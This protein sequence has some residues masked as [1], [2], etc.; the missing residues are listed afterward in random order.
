[1]RDSADL[2]SALDGT[3]TILSESPSHSANI[4][5]IPSSITR[6]EK[7]EKSIAGSELCGEN[8]TRSIVRKEVCGGHRDDSN[9]KAWIHS[10]AVLAS[11]AL[12]LAGSPNWFAA[13]RTDVGSSDMCA[14]RPSSIY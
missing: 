12:S 2:T 6:S 9:C 5:W 7:A 1:M 11:N 10:S 13:C 8:K 14:M 4:D 3:P